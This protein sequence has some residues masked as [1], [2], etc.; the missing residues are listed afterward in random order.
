MDIFKQDKVLASS[1][2]RW[3]DT[4]NEEDNETVEKEVTI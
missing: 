4:F 3:R 1:R 2:N